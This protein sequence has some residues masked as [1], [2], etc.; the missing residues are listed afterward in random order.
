M[1]LNEYKRQ[2]HSLT[3]AKGHSVCKTKTSFSQK[4][5]GHL[6]LKLI[7]KLKRRMEMK[8]YTNVIGHMTKMAAMPIYS[9][10]LKNI[11]FQELIDRWP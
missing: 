8:I 5:L 1:K 9:K 11:F 3:L 6:K 7:R 10:H 2:G 4:L